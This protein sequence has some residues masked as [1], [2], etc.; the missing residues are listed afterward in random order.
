MVIP[1]VIAGG[2]FWLDRS[3]RNRELNIAQDEHEV[4][5]QIA[6]AARETDRLI[7]KEREDWERRIAV[8]A[9]SE[10]T[11]HYYFDRMSE[12]LLKHGLR[13][14]TKNDEVRA[15]AQALTNS[16]INSIDKGRRVLVVKFL[17]DSGFPSV[18]IIYET[19]RPKKLV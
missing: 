6:K 10:N 9:R 7:A 2:A 14:S 3:Q 15:I 12:L 11:L 8:D 13:A 18:S 17:D 16:T 1:A 4:D 19:L 5:R